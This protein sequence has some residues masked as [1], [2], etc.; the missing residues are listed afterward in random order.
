MGSNFHT[1]FTTATRW[2]VGD[3]NPLA[4]DLDRGITYLKNLIIHCDGSLSWTK[5]SGTLTW[6]DVLRIHFNRTDGK[7]IQNTVVAGNIVLADNEFAYID[8]NETNDAV[9]TV[10]KAAITTA[11]ASN[12][13]IY[14]RIVLG[15]R[16]TVSD[17]FYP[18][19]L[20]LFIAGTGGVGDVVGPAGATAERIVLFD[21]ATG[22]LIKDSGILMERNANLSI[23]P[24]YAG[25]VMNADGSNNDPGTLGMT[26]DSETVSDVIR[27][28]YEWKSSLATGLQDYDIVV[29][30][31]MPFN[32]TGF[33]T[34]VSVALTL[35]IKTEEN[36]ITNN[37]I[38]VILQEDGA[39]ATS[40]LTDQKSSVAATWETI[41]FDET[42]AILAALVAGDVLN[43]RIR[44]YSQNSKYVRIGKINLQI[45]LK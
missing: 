10:Q 16:N 7:A 37:K 25:A 26:S 23:F 15:Y 12:F 11:A 39:A 45:K 8:L 33:Q 3:V 42:D 4:S 38:D 30:I 40:S 34:G 32:F 31:P 29:K 27:N 43:V 44:M 1:P 21:G 6:S 24:E 19:Y 28:Y 9:V 2:L 18:V 20:K 13:I 14:N 5:A 22:K 41:G 36:V 35:D 17:E